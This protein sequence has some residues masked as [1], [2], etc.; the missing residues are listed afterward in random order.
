[1]KNRTHV[2]ILIA[3]FAFALI[4]CQKEEQ[5][6]K[7]SEFG[8]AL[9][10]Q[11][12]LDST[13]SRIITSDYI[14]DFEQLSSVACS[15]GY[16]CALSADKKTIEI[17][18]SASTPALG[19]IQLMT[20]SEKVDIL[21]ISSDKKLHTFSIPDANKSHTEV[22]L[23]GDMT[24][25]KSEPMTY[26]NGKWEI[27]KYI[28]P[29][30]YGYQI[31]RD[32]NQGLDPTNP[33]S[34]SNGIG[35]MNSEL[36]IPKPAQDALPYLQLDAIHDS[37]MQ[38]SCRSE[39]THY[40]AFI[41]NQLMATGA[42]EGSTFSLPLNQRNK[43]DERAYVRVYA[44]N[45]VGISNDLLIPLHNGHVITDPEELNRFDLH[46][47]IMYFLMVDRFYN[48]N[49][50]NDAPENDPAIHPMANHHGGDLLGVKQ[51]IQDGY[52][53]QLGANTIW[54]S[55]ILRN[56]KGAYGLWDKGGV[57]SKFSAYHGYWPISFTKIDE[58]FG[59]ANELKG[60]VEAAHQK[61]DNVILDFV[62]NHVHE[63]HP[64]YQ[65]N[66]HNDWATNLYLP[67]SSLNTERWDEHRL[68]T[69]FDVFLPSLNLQKDEITQM[70]SDSAMYLLEEYDLDGFRHD[71]TKHIP[72]K[73]WRTLTKKV[74]SYNTERG[75]P[76]YQIGETY[77]SAELIS[78]YVSSGMLD[79][80]FDFNVYD[81]I[82][83]SVVS[84]DEG[85]E[86]L[87]NRLEQSFQ[88]YGY[89]HLMGNMTGN[90]DKVRFISLASDDVKLDEDGKLAGWTRDISLRTDKAFNKLAMM[91]A[92]NMTIPGI[93]CIYYGD[94]I[95]LPG[96]NDPDNRKMMRFENWSS[97]ESKLFETVSQL[98]HFRRN[99][100]SLMYGNFSILE[101]DKDQL[102]FERAYLNT[103]IVF[104]ANTANTAHTFTYPNTPKNKIVCQAYNGTCDIEDDKINITLPP[105]T[106]EII[107]I[108]SNE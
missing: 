71:A 52:F 48:A 23:V 8:H 34:I 46:T 100:L 90:Q 50:E 103:T 1:M 108:T 45:S 10:S 73:F 7:Q 53:N 82:V 30:Q 89:N 4:S 26:E 39:N 65:A 15:D 47:Q 28:H 56:P 33:N 27:T 98:A 69:W 66:K 18:T 5:G 38:I 40:L 106:F 92:I 86:R 16:S 9:L 37:S 43:S 35:G 80:Q 19:N 99:E 17:A 24:A 3:L 76:I 49:K 97:D 61:D 79:A 91:H 59:T 12:R 20:S 41:D 13:V 55:P 32:D 62:A 83:A 58:R 11:I 44:Y 22:A 96:G 101:A 25:W 36:R 6:I 78:S 93:P 72:L 31:K 68:T 85:L 54:L 67:D 77:G 84:E 81:A 64:V 75:H 60:I 51:K 74:K 2:Q 21:L 29:G 94:E 107:K 104:F 102:A 105:N 95:G 42:V 87:A 14:V 63:E 88:Y 70:L 57:R